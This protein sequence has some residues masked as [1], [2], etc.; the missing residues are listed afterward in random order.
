MIRHF[1]DGWTID[2][3][4]VEFPALKREYIYEALQLSSHLLSDDEIIYA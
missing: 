4:L 1:A 3:L 2:Q